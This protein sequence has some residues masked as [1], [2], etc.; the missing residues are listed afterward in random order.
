V[1][2]VFEGIAGSIVW[3]LA[4]ALYVDLKRKGRSGF[5]RIILFWM[6]IPL[7]WLWLFLIREGSVQEIEE[8]PDDAE[9]LLAEIRRERRLRPE[10]SEREPEE[11]S[12]LARPASELGPDGG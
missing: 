4:N 9:A 3:I 7:T 11:P 2:I 5:S 12:S 6:G 1:E 10:S 8:V